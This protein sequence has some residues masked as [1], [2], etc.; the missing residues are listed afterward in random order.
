ME[1]PLFI[2]K[3]DSLEEELS[4][5]LDKE[6]M[7]DKDYI[8]DLNRDQLSKGKKTDDTSVLSTVGNGNQYTPKYA[9]YK[10]RYA[11]YKNTAYIDL[12]AEGDFYEGIKLKKID[13]IFLNRNSEI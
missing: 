2:D 3:L 4:I 7:K 12:K 8:A 13:K 10:R 11:T 9:S 1:L 6:V 5:Y